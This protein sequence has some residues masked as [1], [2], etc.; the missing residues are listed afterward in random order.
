[1]KKKRNR[2]KKENIYF[3]LAMIGV[4]VLLTVVYEIVLFRTESRKPRPT[5]Q[6]IE[7]E[8]ENEEESEEETEETGETEETE[9]SEK[10]YEKPSYKFRTEEVTVEI[11]DLTR[12]YTLAWVSDVHLITDKE[13]SEDILEEDLEAIKNRYDTLSVTDDGIHGE[14]LWPEI[15]KFLNMGHYDGIIF[16]GDIMDYCSRSN[17]DAFVTEYQKLNPD[18]PVLYVRADHDYGAWYGGDAVTEEITH[19]MHEEV[20]GDD[21]EEKFLNFNDEF[22]VVGVNGSTKNLPAEE[23][24][25]IREQTETGL[26]IILATHVPFSSQVEDQEA[27]LEELSMLVRNKIY[28]WGGPDYQPNE[29]TQELLDKIYWDHTPIRQVLSGHLHAS[30]D[31][32]LTDKVPQHIFTPA[33]KGVIGVVHVVPKE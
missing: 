20:D 26:P 7:I 9:Q 8:P 32:M 24:R 33:F 18:V 27:D 31:G 13:A 4:V 23:M 11:E 15:I 21:L 5:S 28:Y 16:G 14:E 22:M 3:I 12:K 6:E 17:M 30:W 2:K 1:M 10:N 29:V 19:K 25:I